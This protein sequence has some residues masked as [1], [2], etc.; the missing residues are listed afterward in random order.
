MLMQSTYLQ[1]YTSSSSYITFRWIHSM[2]DISSMASLVCS[3]SR[4]RHYLSDWNSKHISLFVLRIR[5]Y[6]Y[7][8]YQIYI[9]QE[10]YILFPSD[11]GYLAHPR[12]YNLNSDVH[13]LRCI[14]FFQDLAFRRFRS[15]MRDLN[16]SKM[17]LELVCNENVT[18]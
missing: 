3:L 8:I 5:L 2:W 4:N 12:I 17:S 15:I 14:R 11:F 6:Y 16:I 7:I 18:T 13:I 1:R 9:N 10:L